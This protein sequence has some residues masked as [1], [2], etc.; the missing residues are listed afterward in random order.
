MGVPL[1]LT[2]RHERG[3]VDYGMPSRVPPDPLTH[4]WLLPIRAVQEGLLW[5][6][7]DA[8]QIIDI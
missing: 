8:W 6:R 2:A 4:V 5:T 1:A 3:A 7:E